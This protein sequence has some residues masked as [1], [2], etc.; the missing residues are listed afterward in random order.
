[1]DGE[2]HFQEIDVLETFLHLEVLPQKRAYHVVP[3]TSLTQMNHLGDTLLTL[4]ADEICY[5]N[6]EVGYTPFSY[7]VLLPQCEGRSCLNVLP[8]DQVYLCYALLC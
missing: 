5:P 7:A 4:S 1:M 3:N 6:D 8:V 2:A